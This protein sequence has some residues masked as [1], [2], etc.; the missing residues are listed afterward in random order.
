M[1]IRSGSGKMRETLALQ[2]NAV[3]TSTGTGF[4]DDNWSTY[5]SVQGEYE[6]PQSGT[7]QFQQ[8][9]VVAVLGPSFRIRYRTDVVPKHRVLWRGQTLQITAV[10]PIMAVGN[11]FLRLQCGMAQ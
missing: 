8:A 10:I 7:E 4:S 5:A 3:Q 6:E 11:R 9:A 1:A 2:S